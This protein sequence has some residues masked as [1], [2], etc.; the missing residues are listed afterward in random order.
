MGFLSSIIRDSRLSVGPRSPEPVPSVSPLPPVA[1]GAEPATM[2]PTDD[3]AVPRA[4]RPYIATETRSPVMRVGDAGPVTFEQDRP[5]FEA[6]ER[7]IR[8]GSPSSSVGALKPPELVSPE[9]VRKSVTLSNEF[10]APRT[11]SISEPWTNLEGNVRDAGIETIGGASPLPPVEEIPQRPTEPQVRSGRRLG[12][13]L[14][15]ATRVEADNKSNGTAD[16]GPVTRVAP[17]DADTGRKVQEFQAEP[18]PPP[19]LT[20]PPSPPPTMMREPPSPFP[21][22]SAHPSPSQTRLPQVRIGQVTVVVEGP[23]PGPAR[24]RPSAPEGPGDRQLLRGL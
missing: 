2:S 18:A 13:V 12:D 1:V 7:D 9:P 14:D 23:N 11:P 17:V 19:A 20:P 24:T 4:P 22:P 21:A 10:T 5:R 15:Y 3:Q 8:S 6:P 16:P